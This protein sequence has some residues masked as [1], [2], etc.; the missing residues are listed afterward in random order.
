[1]RYC[2]AGGAGE[3]R[4]GWRAEGEGV[5]EWKQEED[6][7]RQEEGRTMT[8]KAARTTHRPT[9]LQIPC[10]HA[11]GVCEKVWLVLQPNVPT[12]PPFCFFVGTGKTFPS[13]ENDLKDL[14][15]RLCLL[16][17]DSH[18]PL[19]DHPLATHREPSA[20]YY[21][22]LEIL[23]CNPKGRRALLRIPSTEGRSACLCWPK[24]KPKRPKKARLQ[25]NFRCPP[26]LGARGI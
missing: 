23:Y 3:G 7:Q 13:R 18:T 4:D 15:M 26:M 20:L 5:G 12:W 21:W 6:Y 24:S 17:S 10:F 9:T 1:M 11:N 22:I 8:D 19:E 16:W 2:C 25:N 14:K